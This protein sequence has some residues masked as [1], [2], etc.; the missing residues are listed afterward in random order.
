[1]PWC[2]GN[3]VLDECTEAG[4]ADDKVAADKPEPTD[5]EKD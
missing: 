5:R 2:C 1:M 4:K 3:R